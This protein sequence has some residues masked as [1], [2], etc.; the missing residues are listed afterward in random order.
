MSLPSSPI[1]DD[2]LRD[3][4]ASG[5]SFHLSQLVELD[6]GHGRIVFE[7]DDTIGGQSNRLRQASEYVSRYTYRFGVHRVKAFVYVGG[8]RDAQNEPMPSAHYPI[9]RVS[10]EESLRTRCIEQTIRKMHKALAELQFF[11]LSDEE[12]AAIVTR[13]EQILGVPVAH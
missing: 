2:W 3:K 9:T 8:A 7:W 10:A 6:D 12:R 4:F 1:L 5:A 13:V 11:Q